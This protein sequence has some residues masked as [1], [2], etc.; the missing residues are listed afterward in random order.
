M[1][2]EPEGV[3][4]AESAKHNSVS[5]GFV[6]LALYVYVHMPVYGGVYI[7]SRRDRGLL[8]NIILPSVAQLL[9]AANRK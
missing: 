2:F 8:I 6:L 4:R 3:S 5:C 7:G 9:Q 1:P